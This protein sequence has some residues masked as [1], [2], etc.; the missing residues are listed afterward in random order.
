[1]FISI[2]SSSLSKTDFICISCCV[3]DIGVFTGLSFLERS[4]SLLVVFSSHDGL[5][6]VYAG[7][8]WACDYLLNKPNTVENG[9][10]MKNILRFRCWRFYPSFFSIEVLPFYTWF[11]PPYLYYDVSRHNLVVLV[12]VIPM[13]PR[14]SKMESG[15]K[16]I[17]VFI[18]VFLQ[19]F[20]GPEF[21]D[22]GQKISG[23]ISGLC[24]SRFWEEKFNDLVVFRGSGNFWYTR[25]YPVLDP[26]ISGP[27]FL[28]PVF[29]QED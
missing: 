20:R 7:S 5:W 27:S 19:F 17:V 16:I 24:S 22:L 14:T 8:F 2:P 4:N 26:K 12:V 29:Q 25:K 15:Y 9:V 3:F 1:M 21:S 28:A 23:T 11:H 13:S 18:L 6:C 10:Q